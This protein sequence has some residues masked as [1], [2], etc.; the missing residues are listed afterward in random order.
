MLFLTFMFILEAWKKARLAPH[1]PPKPHGTGGPLE[2]ASVLSGRTKNIDK[3]K[4]L[5]YTLNVPHR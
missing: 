1:F 4:Q 5:L 2:K 3:L